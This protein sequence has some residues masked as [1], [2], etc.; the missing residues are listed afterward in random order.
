MNSALLLF[1][2]RFCV[3]LLCSFVLAPLA[4]ADLL[5]IN[6]SNL[7]GL[8]LG[9]P[10]FTLGFQFNVTTPITVTQL[11]L[12]DSSQNGLLEAHQ[13]GLWDNSGNLLLASVIP[14]GTL[15]PLVDKF[16]VVP[17]TPTNLGVG[18]YRIGA[19]FQTGLD[20]L[21][22][23][24]FATDFI[25]A[26]QLTFVMNRFEPGATLSF[27]TGTDGTQP[28]YFGPNF[29]LAAAVSEPATLMLLGLGLLMFAVARRRSRTR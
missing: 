5:A 18:T 12:F 9:N 25:S 2:S 23:P 10:P 17:V 19:T 13:I 16:R 20:R 24:G 6:F 11:G 21:I 28:A 14:I 29:L 4:R 3:V 27:P 26:P 8:T 7:T 1:R 15:A 22:F